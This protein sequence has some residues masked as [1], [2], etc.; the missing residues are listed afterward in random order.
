MIK[1]IFVRKALAYERFHSDTRGGQA[2]ESR[3]LKVSGAMLFGS[4]RQEGMITMAGKSKRNGNATNQSV[5]G[6]DVLKKT[7]LSILV[8]LSIMLFAGSL[9]ASSSAATTPMA[10]E[11]GSDS[12]KVISINLASALFGCLNLEYETKKSGRHAFALGIL[13][14]IA[15][16]SD[17]H[18]EDWSPLGLTGSY[19][20]FLGDEAPAGSFVGGGLQLVSSGSGSE[21]DNKKAPLFFLGPKLEIGHR[22]I[23]GIFALTLKGEAEYYFAS[24]GEEIAPAPGL[25]YQLPGQG[26]AVGAFLSIGVS[27]E[28]GSRSAGN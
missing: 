21:V 20:Y 25:G 2:P 4:K 26:F 10:V 23:W 15:K 8:F 24:D 14:S 19:R 28:H 6:Y 9:R 18:R 16:I 5:A 7:G 11:S 1:I 22:F 17:D 3:S 27:L 13:K 12:S